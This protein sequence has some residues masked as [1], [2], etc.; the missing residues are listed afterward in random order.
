M[1]EENFIALSLVSKREKKIVNISGQKREIARGKRKKLIAQV[2][3]KK[4]EVEKMMF[5]THAVTK[6]QKAEIRVMV[7]DK[8]VQLKYL[9][10]IM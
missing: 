2:K 5:P 3:S 8:K 6:K 1:K 7:T 9:F 4:N 10:L